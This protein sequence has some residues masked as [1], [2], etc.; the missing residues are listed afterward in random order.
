MKTALKIGLALA[1]ALG[2]LCSAVHAYYVDGENEVAAVLGHPP[3]LE[4][5]GVQEAQNGA[6][7]GNYRTD[8]S[9]RGGGWKQ[10]IVTRN[11]TYVETGDLS[12][13][14]QNDFNLKWI[15]YCE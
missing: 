6:Q 5:E 1:V 2:A 11:S 9:G 7:C 13:V 10:F 3:M 15:Q 12:R 14:G 8:Y 4:F